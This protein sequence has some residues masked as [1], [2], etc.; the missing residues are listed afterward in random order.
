MGL[1]HFKGVRM[2]IILYLLGCVIMADIIA[3]ESDETPLIPWII[4]SLV[5]PL[6]ALIVLWYGMFPPKNP[7]N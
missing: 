2:A 3:E 4:G 5:W 6:E 7:D 1:L